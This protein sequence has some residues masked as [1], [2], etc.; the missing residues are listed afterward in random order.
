MSRSMV[1][2]KTIFEYYNG[3]LCLEINKMWEKIRSILEL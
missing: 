2:E 1:E 3:L